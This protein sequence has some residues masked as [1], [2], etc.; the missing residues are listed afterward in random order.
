M[1]SGGMGYGCY[2]GVPYGGMAYAYSPNWSG[3]YAAVGGSGSYTGGAAA[4]SVPV[5]MPAAGV[6]NPVQTALGAVIPAA[7]AGVVNPATGTVTPG[8]ILTP[9]GGYSEGGVY[10]YPAG[11]YYQGGNYVYPAGYGGFSPGTPYYTTPYGGT[12]SGFGLFRR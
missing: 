8:T 9:T 2:G 10:V 4:R 12:R 1:A 11:G 3:G 5:T 6:Y 7:G